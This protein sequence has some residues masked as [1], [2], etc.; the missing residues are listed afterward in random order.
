MKTARMIRIP[1][2][3]LR[4]ANVQY[5]GEFG[6]VTIGQGSEAGD[7]S[8]YSD[9][10]GVF[11]IGHGAGTSGDRQPRRYFGSLDAGGRTNMIRY[12]TP[13]IGPMSAAVSVGN[14]DRVSAQTRPQHRVQRHV[15]RGEGRH[16]AGE[17][18]KKDTVGASFGATLASGLTI[19]GAWARANNHGRLE[20]DDGRTLPS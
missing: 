7:G 8:A 13:A 20:R 16:P 5:G 18:R 4:H 2:S 10:T 14:G 1:S 12:D 11:G 17:G 9:T 19:S 15:V 6:K 3:R